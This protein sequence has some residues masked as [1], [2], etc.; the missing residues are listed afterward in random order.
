M[1]IRDSIDTAETDDTLEQTIV[2][3]NPTLFMCQLYQMTEAITA[4]V[5]D[6]MRDHLALRTDLAFVLTGLD[7]N[8]FGDRLNDIS[9]IVT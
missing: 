8:V 9:T 4:Y 6:P 1:C 5:A 7:E 2:R 3:I